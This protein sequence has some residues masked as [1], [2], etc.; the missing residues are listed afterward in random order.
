MI[1]TIIGIICFQ[2]YWIHTLYTDERSALQKMT[3]VL[4]KKSIQQLQNT[5][6]K[7]DSNYIQFPITKNG[8][9]LL[10]ASRIIEPLQPFI[11]KD[12]AFISKGVVAN[13]SKKPEKK[14][15]VLQSDSLVTNGAIQS[16]SFVKSSTD[17]NKGIDVSEIKKKLLDSILQKVNIGGSINI[18]VKGDSSKLHSAIMQTALLKKPNN[19]DTVKVF[20]QSKTGTIVSQEKLKK[21][22]VTS[23][24]LQIRTRFDSI[25]LQKLD[26]SYSKNLK[27][28]AINIPYK[29]NMYVAKD[30]VKQNKA[31][32]LQTSFA[33][34]GFSCPYYY[35]A[36]FDN[37]F[38]FI[39]KRLALPILVSLLLIGI[40]ALSFIYLYKSLQAQHRLSVI[41]NDFISN[42]THEL[43]TPIATVTV[44]VEALKNFGL[45]RDPEKTK[46]YLEI[47]SSELQRLSLLVDKV[48]KLAM[49]ENKGID[50]NKESFDLRNLTQEIL[51][52]MK[53]QIEKQSATVSFILH[54]NDFMVYADKLH[55]TSVL[56]NLIDNAL[57]YS[58]ENPMLQVSIK[59]DN[60]RVE[61]EIKD[62]GIGVA[63]EYQQK[64]F[65]KF[66]RVPMGDRHNIK[67]YGLGLSYV[68]Q[69]IKKHG[70]EILVKS[71]LG[72]G[73][74]FT[75][76]LP[77]ENIEPLP[78][79]QKEI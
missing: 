49:F 62:N 24:I 53:L 38:T 13:T 42:I 67:G 46:E 3:D 63:K 39:T 37:P 1:A 20:T 56:Y 52:T 76:Y 48:L 43:K 64:I 7:T 22:I 40:T 17:Q 58:N 41:K 23:L 34:I 77:K 74:A 36:T 61:L 32:P 78:T 35:R 59:Q 65:D 66:F 25:P 71:E 31:L 11:K 28:N 29:L 45:I 47:S 5:S 21:G 68:H 72:Q 30:T 50:L 8:N 18:V 51:Q 19:N 16:I 33:E 69:V 4:L 79:S 54:G 55:I 12:T 14:I 6:V 44:A 26:S 2:A 75:I 60:H 15:I 27:D 73:S 10:Q 9:Q 57:K 70:G